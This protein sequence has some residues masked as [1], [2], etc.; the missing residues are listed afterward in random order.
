MSSVVI[1]L[2]KSVSEA[3]MEQLIGLVKEQIKEQSGQD[4][5]V[6]VSPIPASSPILYIFDFHAEA[7][8]AKNV[9]EFVGLAARSVLTK[10]QDIRILMMGTT[11]SVA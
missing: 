1:H 4:V 3:K 10:A 7:S 2:P 8:V 11:T 6:T 9:H 5:P